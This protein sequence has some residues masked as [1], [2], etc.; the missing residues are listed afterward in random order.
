VRSRPY[1]LFTVACSPVHRIVGIPAARRTPHTA[2]RRQCEDVLLYGKARAALVGRMN[3]TFSRRRAARRD[4]SRRPHPPSLAAARRGRRRNGCVATR[5]VTALTVRSTRSRAAL[6]TVPTLGVSGQISRDR[7]GR[8]ARSGCSTQALDEPQ[9]GA[10][11]SAEVL[12][13]MPVRPGTRLRLVM[14]GHAGSRGELSWSW[15]D[16][17]GAV[18]DADAVD[19][20]RFQLGQNC[21]EWI[22]GSEQGRS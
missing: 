18:G 8:P 5:P 12:I 19:E 3:S 1:D 6:A 9:R 11:R 21:P 17:R 16:D 15:L 7:E 10:G 22:I 14:R 2:A 20:H 13:S 4:R